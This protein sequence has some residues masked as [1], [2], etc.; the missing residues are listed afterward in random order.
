MVRIPNKPKLLT[1]QNDDTGFSDYSV[2]ITGTLIGL[3]CILYQ[4][5]KHKACTSSDQPFLCACSLRSSKTHFFHTVEETLED[6]N[7]TLTALPQ[8]LQ[9]DLK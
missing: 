9:D 6:N 7:N 1:I 8:D 5:A 4:S 3:N 2:N